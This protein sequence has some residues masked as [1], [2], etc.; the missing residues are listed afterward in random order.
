MKI[1]NTSSKVVEEKISEKEKEA[2]AQVSTAPKPMKKVDVLEGLR[3]K[4]V[5]RSDKSP[6]SDLKHKVEPKEDSSNELD[7]E[8]VDI[9]NEKSTTSKKEEVV[10]VKLD[11]GKSTTSK[12]ERLLT[13]PLNKEAQAELPMEIREEFKAFDSL[14]R[15]LRSIGEQIVDEDEAFIKGLVSDQV[16]IIYGGLVEEIAGKMMDGFYNDIDTESKAL[17]IDEEQEI[18]FDTREIKEIVSILLEI[19]TENKNERFNEEITKVFE[20]GKLESEILHSENFSI[21]FFNLFAKLTKNEELSSLLKNRGERLSSQYLYL[22]DI[23][24]ID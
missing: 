4:R 20:M 24:Q 6:E 1:K 3:K 14:V 22:E 21:P 15:T 10:E 8:K 12:K 9:D 2:L 13:A 23:F 17:G 7:L 11:E 5:E 18:Y 16:E 19:N